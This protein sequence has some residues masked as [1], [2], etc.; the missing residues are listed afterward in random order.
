MR[1]HILSDLHLEFAPFEMPVVDADVVVLAGDVDVGH[2]GLKW[3]RAAIPQTPVIYV[4]GNHEFYGQTLPKL[5]DELCQEASGTNVHVLENSRIDLGDVTFLGATL[6]TDFAL[7]GDPV[8]GGLVAEQ[9]MNDFRQIRTSPGYRKL[10]ASYLRRLNADSVLWLKNE[11]EACRGRKLVIVTHCPP[12]ARS[13]SPVYAGE[14]LNA[15]FASNL[16]ALV[17]DSG[18]LLWIHG[19]THSAA[20]Y[21]IG[22]THVIGN[23]RGYPREAGSAFKPELV[24]EI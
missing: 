9:G 10:R 23:P 16:D 17:A 12:S 20:D 1:L 15:A 6:W 4:L 11:A 7:N 21:T 18:A 24:V 2:N 22:R 14:P 13:I 8:L 19:H 3:I 5:T